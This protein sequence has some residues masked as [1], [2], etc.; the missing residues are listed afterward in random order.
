MHSTKRPDN[1]EKTVKNTYTAF[2][3][4]YKLDVRLKKDAKKLRMMN[5]K[6]QFAR[7]IL[8]KYSSVLW[9]SGMKLRLQLK[10]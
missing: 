8:E 9:I 2:P 7:F 1:S 10:R 6:S 3:F 4:T 5:E